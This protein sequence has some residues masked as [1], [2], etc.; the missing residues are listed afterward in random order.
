MRNSS[1]FKI[2]GVAGLVFTG[3]LLM[4]GDHIDSPAVAGTSSDLASLYAFE[5]D[6]PNN[7]VFIATLQAALAPGQVTQNAQF[8]EDVM[9]EFNIDNTGD[10]VEDLVIQ[11]I[12]RGD[13]MYFFG[14]AQ[15][16]RTG[17]E[18]EVITFAERNVVKI[19]AVDDV[20]I[21]TNN[22]MSFFAGPRRDPFFFDLDR[23]RNI[24]SKTVVPTGFLP[25]GEAT[26]YYAG[27][28]V[29]SVAV[30]VPNSMLGTPPSHIGESFGLTNL[31]PSYNVWVSTKRKQ[32]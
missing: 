12:K 2:L 1:F 21:T 16:A 31:P 24:T 18:S 14:P 11:A 23:F 5:G 29:L 19:S 4:S 25:E 15:P 28:N 17:L 10:F 30:E 26:D 32:Q 6:S 7:T 8:D 3:G 9:V 20:Q 22:G 13:S 27:L